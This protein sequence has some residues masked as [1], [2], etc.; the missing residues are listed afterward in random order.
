V[1][2]LEAVLALD[3]VVGHDE[4]VEPRAEV[5]EGVGPHR[6]LGGVGRDDQAGGAVEHVEQ[7]ARGQGLALAARPGEVEAAVL[8]QDLLGVA[9]VGALVVVQVHAALGQLDLDAPGADVEVEG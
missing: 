1:G 8:A 6:L 2:L 9:Q 3:L 7:A 4:H 5:G